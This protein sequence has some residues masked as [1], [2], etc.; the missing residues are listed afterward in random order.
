M[1]MQPAITKLHKATTASLRQNFGQSNKSW[2]Q[3]DFTGDKFVGGGDY[4]LFELMFPKNFNWA[5]LSIRGD[6]DNDYDVDLTDAVAFG[7]Y[8][9][10]QNPPVF[11]QI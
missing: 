6:Y 5:N 3:G 11:L 1:Q 10:G 9:Y 8:Y 4:E 2:N 7:N